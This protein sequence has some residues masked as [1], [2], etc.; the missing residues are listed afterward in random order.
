M[1]VFL[2]FLSTS[3][4]Y[5]AQKLLQWG[6]LEDLLQS[7]LSFSNDIEIRLYALKAISNIL[8]FKNEIIYIVNKMTEFEFERLLDKIIPEEYRDDEDIFSI[9]REIQLNLQREC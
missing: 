9:V 2:T 7:S 5:D 8:S 3:T 1:I 4:I 6:F